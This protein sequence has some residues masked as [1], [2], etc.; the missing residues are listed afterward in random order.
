MSPN[1]EWR[2]TFGRKACR[3]G[4]LDGVLFKGNHYR[5]FGA[6][7]QR[8]LGDMS[9]IYHLSL[10]WS[11]PH[12]NNQAAMG[13]LQVY[14]VPL[15][16]ASASRRGVWAQQLAHCGGTLVSSPQPG[17]THV[18]LA[19]ELTWQR[20]LSGIYVGEQIARLEVAR[21]GMMQG[22]IGVWSMWM[23]VC[24]FR[25]TRLWSFI[26]LANELFLRLSTWQPTLILDEASGCSCAT[27]WWQ[28]KYFLM[29]TLKMGKIPMFTHIF[30][31]G[32]VETTNH[33]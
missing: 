16:S 1:S 26:H 7:S 31:I 23:S 12:S 24:F 20:P 10:W 18:A 17:L 32:W 21:N 4:G 3:R 15:A 5:H 25:W 19:P 11:I 28:L 2:R 13:C 30:Q 33:L 9:D 22:A 14:V 29:F 8:N 6:M 27:R